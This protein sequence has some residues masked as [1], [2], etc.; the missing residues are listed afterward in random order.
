MDREIEADFAVNR[1]AAW[2]KNSIAIKVGEDIYPSMAAAAKALDCSNS[3]VSIRIKNGEL[4]KGF[5]VKKVV[6]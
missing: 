5:K 1:Q 6:K 2:D 3:L 4:L